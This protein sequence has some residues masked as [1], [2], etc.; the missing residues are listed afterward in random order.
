MGFFLKIGKEKTLFLFIRNDKQ[1]LKN[2]RPVSLLQICGK[3]FERL[4]WN[5]IF[6]FFI[7][8]G[9]ISQNHSGFIPGHFCINKLL[10]ISHD[11]L[12][13]FNDGWEVGSIFLDI[14]KTSDK[15]WHQSVILKLDRNRISGY[16]LKII[17]DYLKSSSERTSFWMGW[18]E[19]WN[20]P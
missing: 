19:C 13:P 9:L 5:S 17:E 7:E 10:S 1:S 8:N 20:L 2:Y 15:V 14:S 6:C 4:L 12:K 16:L 11:I 3:I 18:R